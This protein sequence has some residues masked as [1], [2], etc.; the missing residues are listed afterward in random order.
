M[1]KLIVGLVTICSVVCFSQ[2]IPSGGIISGGQS[3]S[4]GGINVGAGTNIIAVTNSGAVTLSVANPST[5]QIFNNVTFTGIVTN[6]GTSVVA[7]QIIVGSN[8][9]TGVTNGMITNFLQ[10]ATNFQYDF[11][12]GA[13]WVTNAGTNICFSNTI[14]GTLGYYNQG[15]IFLYQTNSG[16][17]TFKYG[18]GVGI[19]ATNGTGPIN[20][21]NANNPYVIA[22]GQFGTNFKTAVYGIAFPN[23]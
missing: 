3:G 1:K 5:G 23:N 16:V 7:A 11:S 20:V 2:T 22:I 4:G 14:S 19:F 10:A 18:G 12:F 8:T 13:I 15:V 9:V 17:L 21:T 6:T